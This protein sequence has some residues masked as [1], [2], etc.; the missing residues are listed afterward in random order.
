MR[1]RQIASTQTRRLVLTVRDPVHLVAIRK[2]LQEVGCYRLAEN[3]SAELSR[4]RRDHQYS[5]RHSDV[6][7]VPGQTT[8]DRSSRRSKVNYDCIDERQRRTAD[9][10]L[11]RRRAR[12]G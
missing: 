7:S 1:L 9:E 12:S 4:Y 6:P 10:R 8:A 11:L 2:C 3:E 5:D